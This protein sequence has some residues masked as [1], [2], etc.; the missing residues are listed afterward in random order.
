MSE[1]NGAK[2]LDD[3]RLE[4]VEDRSVI[5]QELRPTNKNAFPTA[6]YAD[7]IIWMVGQAAGGITKWGKGNGKERDK[8]LR[9]FALE[10]SIFLSAL[11]IMC[12]RNAGFSWKI[13][14]PNRTAGILQ[15]VLDTANLG[16]GWHD[17]ILKTS[18]DLYTQDSGA[19]WEI[20]RARSGTPNSPVIGINHLDA[21]RCYHTGNRERPVIY[22]DDHGQPH[23]LEWYEVVTFSE[24]PTAIKTQ[25]GMQYSALTRL[26]TKMQI[27]NNIDIY[28]YEK[29]AGRN[30]KAVHLVQ[31][32]TS[33]QLT[34]A[35]AQAGAAA[36]TAGLTRFMNP[37]ILGTLDPKATVAHDTIEMVGMPEGW[38]PEEQFKQYINHIAMAF[39][40]DYQEFAP[41]PGG[42]LG[43]GAQSEM[44]HMKSKGKGPGLF[45]KMISHAINFRVFP[46]NARFTYTEQDLEA[47]KQLADIKFTR[48]QTRQ[49]QIM[50]GEITTQVARQ[51]ANDQ[52]DLPLELLSLMGEQDVTEDVMVN[53]SVQNSSLNSD[54]GKPIMSGDP[55]PKGPPGSQ[56]NPGETPGTT[57]KD[58]PLEPKKR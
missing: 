52:G 18:I 40:S 19:F 39:Q 13:E 17:L 26:L 36:T 12:S 5:E 24:M 32:V 54:T 14:A 43:T 37:I 38:N 55:A 23:V 21:G 1:S 27:Q 22:V 51:L 34:D 20:V 47:E 46:G 7:Q 3:A 9:S 45:M 16:E 6:S 28:D 29:T 48:A 25:Y 57:K 30:Y 53:D 31:G 44:L 8:Q 15:D 11:G 42:G 2:I 49:V 35:I 4:R 33:Q 58:E 56:V 41:L 50:S 10:E